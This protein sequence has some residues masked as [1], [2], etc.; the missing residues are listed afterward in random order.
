MT[1]FP[2]WVGEVAVIFVAASII[3]VVIFLVP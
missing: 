1:N 2:D 3:Y